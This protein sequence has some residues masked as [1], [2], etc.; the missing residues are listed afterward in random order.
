MAYPVIIV[1][2]SFG[3]CNKQKEVIPSKFESLKDLWRKLLLNKKILASSI[4]LL[5]LTS[6]LVV[7]VEAVATMWVQTYGA[8]GDWINALVETSD[9]GYALAGGTTMT[10]DGSVRN[11]F[12]LVKTDAFGFQEWNQSYPRT[13]AE[14]ASALVATSDGGYAMV[15]Q[16]YPTN[17]S[18][19]TDC[20]LVKTD[21]F[22]NME[23]NQTYGGTLDEYPNALVEAPDGGYAMAG[24]T[25]SFGSG[26]Q[27]FWLVKT[28]AS[29]NVEWNQTYG[30]PYY[31]WSYSLVATSD[32]GYAIVGFTDA[33]YGADGNCW[34]VKTDAFGNMEWNQTYGKTWGT[35][36]NDYSLVEASDGGY[37]IACNTYSDAKGTDCWWFKTDAF[38]N[39]EWNQTYGKTGNDD[40]NA[41]I[42]T[43][44]GGYALAGD[45]ISISYMD[46]FLIKTDEL[47]N[48]PEAVWVVLPLVLT[49]TLAVFIIKK[50]LLRSCS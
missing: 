29:G 45:S 32:G 27:D 30:G 16:T 38:G 26:C 25:W 41:L 44:D 28:D 33:L 42:A 2:C 24:Y 22:G 13:M 48:V 37:A 17:K 6:S 9:G 50:K 39:M 40:V 20:W 5:V 14:Y 46:I 36:E 43:S 31:D 8:P 49:A 15:G 10:I 3:H 34:L 47:G 4:I 1:S 19:Y 35:T 18:R 12:F 11:G 7:S 21:A 23:W